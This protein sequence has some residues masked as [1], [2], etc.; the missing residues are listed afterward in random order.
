MVK[1]EGKIYNLK[2]GSQDLISKSKI[3]FLR[4]KIK[5]FAGGNS[6]FVSPVDYWGKPINDI[7]YIVDLTSIY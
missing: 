6:A 5:N 7:E 4:I 1:Q 2:K 3:N